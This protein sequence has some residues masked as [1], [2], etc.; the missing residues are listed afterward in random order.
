[1]FAARR[2][3]LVALVAVLLVGGMAPDAFASRGRPNPGVAAQK[4]FFPWLLGDSTNPL[5]RTGFC[6]EL[7]DGTFLLTAGGA[8]HSTARCS[9]P[10]GTPVLGIAGAVAGW[11]AS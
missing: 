8:G 10:A 9:I 3:G 7:V 6:G 2:V 5:A 4:R 1:M 11:G